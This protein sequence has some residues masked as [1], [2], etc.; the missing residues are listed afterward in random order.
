M[1]WRKYMILK[2]C[3]IF[4][5]ENFIPDA[6]AF[7]VRELGIGYSLSK[8]ASSSIGLKGLSIGVFARNPF[9][10]FAK[11]NKGYA[12]PETSISGGNLFGIT[13]T[14]QYPST[15]VYGINTTINF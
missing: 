11:E 4:N 3:R 10:K 13:G 14:N 15:K 9:Y 12:D 8:E 7:K 2:N 5:G 6:T 1:E